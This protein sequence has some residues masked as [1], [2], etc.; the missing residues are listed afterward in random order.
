MPDSPP[1]YEVCIHLKALRDPQGVPPAIRL[2][3]FL[4]SAL[5]TW[6]FR[7]TKLEPVSIEAVE[8]QE[9]K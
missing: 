7:C 6:S 5:R 4:K 8:Q 2:K 9:A 3:Q 1:I